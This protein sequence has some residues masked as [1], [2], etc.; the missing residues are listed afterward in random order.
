MKLKIMQLQKDTMNY[1]S[2]RKK[3]IEINKFVEKI[4]FRYTKL[5]REE[6]IGI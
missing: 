4:I 3:Q 2:I 1:E 5:I 6:K